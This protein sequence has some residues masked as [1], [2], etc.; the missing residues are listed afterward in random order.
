[1]NAI[2]SRNLCHFVALRAHAIWLVR[3]RPLMITSVV[4]QRCRSMQADSVR[5]LAV[6]EIVGADRGPDLRSVLRFTALL[7]T[8]DRILLKQ[9]R[10]RTRSISRESESRR[11]AVTGRAFP[12]RRRSLGS[13]LT[14]SN[15]GVQEE[16]PSK[17]KAC[18]SHRWRSHV[19]DSDHLAP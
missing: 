6:H 12:G 5:A 7:V 13:W 1:M 16:P 14:E 15:R 17:A 9:R 11:R 4:V 19:V 18:Q 3:R 8:V 10:P 2:V